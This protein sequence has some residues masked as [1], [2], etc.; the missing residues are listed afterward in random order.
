MSSEATMG[1]VPDV[2]GQVHPVETP[3][4]IQT[5]LIALHKEL[6]QLP[7]DK[8]I[9]WK[10]AQE[11]CPHLVNEDFQLQFLRCEVFNTDVS[12]RCGCMSPAFAFTLQFYKNY[13]IFICRSCLL[14]FI[15]ALLFSTLVA[16]IC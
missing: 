1:Q 13:Q 3:E 14:V 5:K 16:F 6:A 4:L 15:N 7:T 8:T 11:Q 9:A 2:Y 10:Q 12:F